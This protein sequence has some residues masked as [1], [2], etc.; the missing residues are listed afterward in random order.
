MASEVDIANR[1]LSMLGEQRITSL[2]DNNKPARAMNARYVLLRDAELTSYP[3]RFAVK[4]TQLAASTDVPE[5][6]YSTIYDRPV[7]DLKPIKVGGAA[8]NGEAI[9]VMYESTGFSRDETAYEI[10]EGRIHTNLSAP[11]D[12]EYIAR[13]TDAGAFDPL[14]VEALA[15]RLAA[16]A[17]EELTQ[18]NSKKEA[19]LFT[20][21]KTLSDARRV[22]SLLRPPRRRADG[23]WMQSRIHG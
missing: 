14:F 13:I 16:D 6:G 21:K 2:S 9:G 23:R 19:A 7:D 8:V 11:L 4:R 10:I 22:N 18:S 17:A 1:A 5:W 12:Y 20:Y 3:W 15:S